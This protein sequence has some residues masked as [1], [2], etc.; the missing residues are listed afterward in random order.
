MASFVDRL[1]CSRCGAEFDHR[2][3]EHLC[4]CGGPLLVDYDLAAVAAAVGPAAISARVGGGIWRFHELLPVENPAAAV[5][6]G[7][8]GTPMVGAP[9][10][11][12]A[13]GAGA[14]FVKDEGLN[15]TGS[16]KARGAACGIPAAVERGVREVALPTAGNA[17]VAWAAYG[18]AAGLEVHVAMSADAPAANVEAVRLLGGR[19]TL[20]DG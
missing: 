14:V 18:A 4:H 7:E 11:A 8:G 17:G 19:L 20:V 12:S 10:L 1:V 9:Q 3:R 13:Q 6:L 5:T 15:P 16:F 2:G